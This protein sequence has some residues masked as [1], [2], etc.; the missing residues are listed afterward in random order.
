LNDCEIN[1]FDRVDGMREFDRV[2]G[3]E[4]D[5]WVVMCDAA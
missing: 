5:R 1:S 4:F 3:M 2:D